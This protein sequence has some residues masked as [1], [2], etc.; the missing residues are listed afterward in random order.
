MSHGYEK[1]LL[2]QAIDNA[3]ITMRNAQ[4]KSCKDNNLAWCEAT[5]LSIES[6]ITQYLGLASC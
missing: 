1:K 2:D 5:T 4:I 3:T 6:G